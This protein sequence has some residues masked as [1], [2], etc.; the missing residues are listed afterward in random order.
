MFVD[1]DVLP[2]VPVVVVVDILPVVPVVPV[3]L[4]VP[5]VPVVF[6]EVPDVPNILLNEL[7]L[8][9]VVAVAILPSQTQVYL[10]KS[11]VNPLEHAKQVLELTS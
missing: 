5:V 3:V 9:L 8:V 11:N 10:F 6:V 4:V 1:V 2:E 7:S